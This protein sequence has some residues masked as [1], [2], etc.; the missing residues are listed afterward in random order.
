MLSVVS[1]AAFLV[2]AGGVLG[3]AAGASDTGKPR[4]E[5]SSHLRSSSNSPPDWTTDVLENVRGSLVLELRP[6]KTVAVAG[7]LT[8]ERK[9]TGS[10]PTMGSGEQHCTGSGPAA[11][12]AFL[13]AGDLVLSLDALIPCAGTSR[14]Q[15]PGLGASVEAYESNVSVFLPRHS[16]EYRDGA[17]ATFEEEIEHGASHGPARR[18]I[19]LTLTGVGPTRRLDSLRSRTDVPR[20]PWSIH[21]ETSGRSLM[22]GIGS[23]FSGRGHGPLQLSDE[24]AVAVV[25]AFPFALEVVPDGAGS[26]GP[27]GVTA[28]LHL[29]GESD[30]ASVRFTSRLSETETSWLSP[31]ASIEWSAAGGGAVSFVSPVRLRRAV[32]GLEASFDCTAEGPWVPVIPGTEVQPVTL[33][34][35]AGATLAQSL[36]CN[37]TVD[38]SFVGTVKGQT[39]WTLEGPERQ[40]WLAR[41]RGWELETLG[42]G[43]SESVAKA[44]RFRYD[45]TGTFILEKTDGGWAYRPGRISKT[46][47]SAVP[48]FEPANL[49]DCEERPCSPASAAMSG[50]LEGKPLFGHLV[51]QQ[52]GLAWWPAQPRACFECRPRHPDLP[53]TTYSV[54][55]T[56]CSFMTELGLERHPLTDG[57]SAAF[58]STPGSKAEHLGYTITLERLDRE[59]PR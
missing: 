39:T 46:T 57:Y 12:E 52:V 24:A 36:D 22:G 32:D 19:T 51:G 31:E 13:V 21:V 20:S 34:L 9:I 7:T 53:Q 47:I 27:L 33:E 56:S 17:S 35:S 26:G 29:S 49:Y 38:G 1:R 14:I 2:F 54:E 23:R 25:A 48:E 3:W 18:T 8:A 5:V 4:L 11:G 6:D 43:A 58:P 37:L 16:V 55:A 10:S 40:T 59:R 28:T 30:G 41:V 15:V 42:R 50:S 45:L 44:F